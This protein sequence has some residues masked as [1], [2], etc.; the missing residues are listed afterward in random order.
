MA[1]TADIRSGLILKIDGNLYS[2]IEFGQNKT[3]RAAAKVWAKLKGVDNSR[4]IEQTWNSGETIYPVRVERKA[5]QFLYKD[6]SGYSFMDNETFEQ[7]TVAE[8]MVDAP[9]FLK[10]GQEVSVLING[11]TE[12]PMGVELPDKIVL[13]V[14]YSE[15]GIKGDTATRTLKPATLETG[16]SINVPLFVNEGELIRINSKTGEYVER[17]K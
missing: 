1:T 4:T 2:V 8:E 12:L 14:T 16:A 5:F 15:P 10:E 13:M 17:V 9:A 11:E 7:I 6:D 3:A